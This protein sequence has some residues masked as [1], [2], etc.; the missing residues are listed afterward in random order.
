M[1]RGIALIVGLV[2]LTGCGGGGS[3]GG[4]PTPGQTAS[5]SPTPTPPPAGVKAKIT[6]IDL[7]AVFTGTTFSKS[8]NPGVGTANVR[9]WVENLR[10][11]APGGVTLSVGGV[12]QPVTGASAGIG[13]V[14]AVLNLQNAGGSGVIPEGTW[15]LE[16]TDRGE[17]VEQSSPP[18]TITIAP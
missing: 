13:S 12:S 18:V 4:T 11:T 7:P 2:L 16:M 9:I 15:Q 17:A 5:P 10:S 8:A 6:R 14:T 3:G 1:L